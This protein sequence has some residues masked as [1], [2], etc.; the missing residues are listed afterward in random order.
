[1]QDGPGQTLQDGSVSRAGRSS[2]EELP[3]AKAGPSEQGHR[4]YKRNLHETTLIEK[5][6]ESERIFVLTIPNNYRHSTREEP[7]PSLHFQRRGCE[8]G[9]EGQG[10]PGGGAHKTALGQRSTFISGD[11]RVHV[12][13]LEGAASYLC[14]PPET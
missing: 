11:K 4:R 10:L 1:M 9:G 8:R 14:S 13:T 7:E 2:L 3:K 5:Q 6:G 12:C